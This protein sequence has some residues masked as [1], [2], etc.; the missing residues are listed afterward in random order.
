MTRGKPHYSKI[1]IP[2]LCWPTGATMEPGCVR[3]RYTS[4]WRNGLIATCIIN[5]NKK[6]GKYKIVNFFK[7]LNHHQILG[8]RIK[9]DFL[10]ISFALNFPRRSYFRSLSRLKMLSPAN[11]TPYSGQCIKLSPERRA[12]LDIYVFMS[13]P[14]P[15]LSRNFSQGIL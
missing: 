14:T 11:Y 1:W 13:T 9:V 5:K 4:T 12:L 3:Y 15:I 8:R 10:K 6:T 7:K 2:V